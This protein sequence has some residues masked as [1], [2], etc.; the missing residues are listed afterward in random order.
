MKN[1]Q[2]DNKYPQNLSSEVIR[3]AC[4]GQID[5]IGEVIDH[6]QNYVYATIINMMMENGFAVDEEF[7]KDLSQIVWEKVIRK[8]LWIFDELD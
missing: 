5:A 2:G 4:D 6:Y 7:V 3:R 1:E 8:R